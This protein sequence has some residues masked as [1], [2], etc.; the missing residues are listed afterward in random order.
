MDRLP[1]KSNSDRRRQ[2]AGKRASSGAPLQVSSAR[3]SSAAVA[4]G[5]R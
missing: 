5:R 3:I 4:P 1:S 2:P